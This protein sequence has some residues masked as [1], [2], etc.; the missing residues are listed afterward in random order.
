M[1]LKIEDIN[2][3]GYNDSNDVVKYISNKYMFKPDN[4]HTRRCMLH[5]IEDFYMKRAN[6]LD[7][8]YNT[9]YRES[10]RKIIQRVQIAIYGNL[11]YQ[12]GFTDIEVHDELVE[13]FCNLE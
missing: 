9:S 6:Y 3:F 10:I 1:E 8:H 7:W 2:P 13:T 11:L 4:N 5:D 12:A